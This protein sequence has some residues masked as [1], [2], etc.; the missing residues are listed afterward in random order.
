MD[1]GGGSVLSCP[2]WYVSCTCC[3]K[4]ICLHTTVGGFKPLDLQWS[5]DGTA[6]LLVDRK[7]YCCC[8]LLYE[9]EEQ[10]EVAV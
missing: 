7:C 10:E 4:A 2:Y 6:L 8:Y 1:P 3:I 5:P 9:D